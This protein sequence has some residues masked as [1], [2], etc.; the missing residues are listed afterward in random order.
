MLNSET[1]KIR[2]GYKSKRFLPRLSPIERKQR[3]KVV[4][5]LIAET[6]QNRK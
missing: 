2:R 5:R 3:E 1:P 4:I 6:M